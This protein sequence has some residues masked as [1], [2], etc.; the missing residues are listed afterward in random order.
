MSCQPCVRGVSSCSSVQPQ[1]MYTYTHINLPSTSSI[2]GLRTHRS[3]RRHCVSVWF[4]PNRTRVDDIMAFLG[5]SCTY[6]YYKMTYLYFFLKKEGYSLY[7]RATN[8]GVVRSSIY[9]IQQLKRLYRVKY[10]YK[11]KIWKTIGKKISIKDLLGISSH[12]EQV[13]NR[14][15]VK[16]PSACPWSTPIW[17]NEQDSLNP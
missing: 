9:I 11:I 16:P 5:P 2:I 3:S 13:Y 15:R 6:L 1:G 4:D 12:H 14:S 7:F 10:P 17:P 8:V